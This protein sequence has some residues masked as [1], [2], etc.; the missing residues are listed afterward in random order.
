VQLGVTALIGCGFITMRNLQGACFATCIDVQ[1][2]GDFNTIENC[3]FHGSILQNNTNQVAY[4]QANATIV[5]LGQVDHILINGV[6]GYGFFRGIHSDGATIRTQIDNCNFDSCRIGMDL[7]A[8]SY[9]SV[10]NTSIV[11]CAVVALGYGIQVQGPWD[12]NNVWVVNSD[13]FGILALGA[14]AKVNLQNV[15]IDQPNRAGAG[16]AALYASTNGVI[17]YDIVD[18]TRHTGGPSFFT[19]TGGVIRQQAIYSTG[20][21]KFSVG[22]TNTENLTANR[23][24]T[25]KVNNANRTVDLNGNLSILGSS[26]TFGGP[27]ELVGSS[28][29]IVRTTGSTDITLP[30]SGTLATTGS[31]AQFAA[32][33]SLELKSLISDETGSGAL[34]FATSPTLVTPVLGVA[35]ATSVN[36][37]GAA[38]SNYSEGS[39]TPIDSSGAGLAFTSVSAN[40]TRIGRMVFAYGALTYPATADASVAVI[41]GLPFAAANAQYARQCSLSLKTESTLATMAPVA[42]TTTITLFTATGTAITNATMSGDLVYFMCIYPVS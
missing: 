20:T 11:G 2:S 13:T 28:A 42:N 7:S 26:C 8:T 4:I 38:L 22:W 31:L 29:W 19:D 37:G 39:W 24:V 3:T 16:S 21:G 30:L 17:E 18:I 32:T 10:S 27:F 14:A 35:A 6:K 41:G 9:G 23:T 5:K 36:F 34:V 33:T 40:Y 15:H 12:F 1:L 25:L